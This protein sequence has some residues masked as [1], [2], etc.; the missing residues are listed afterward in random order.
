MGQIE[1][2]PAT[3]GTQPGPQP[4]AAA[5]SPVVQD[6]QTEQAANQ[7]A[8]EGAAKPTAVSNS[9]ATPAEDVG[10][11]AYSSSTGEFFG[12]SKS[13]CNLA[14]IFNQDNTDGGR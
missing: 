10:T 1:S 3:G 4:E 14:P 8:V 2:K 5:G 9:S 12:H 13:T 11:T 6:V 7:P